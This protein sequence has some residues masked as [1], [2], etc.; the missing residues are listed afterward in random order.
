MTKMRSM[1]SYT[2]NRNKCRSQLLLE[3]FGEFGSPKCGRCDYC[4]NRHRK[5][6]LNKEF[7]EILRSVE[8]H[9]K[10]NQLSIE[11]LLTRLPRYNKDKLLRALQWLQDND[12]IKV[13][14][15]DIVSLTK[16]E[17]KAN[18]KNS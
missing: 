13:D 10:T 1:L 16:I 8:S 5:G 3:Y 15:Q 9:L 18:T 11:E 14:K 2:E 17:S 4:L 12:V 6:I 7:D